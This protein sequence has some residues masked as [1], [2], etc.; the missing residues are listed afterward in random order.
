[1][2]G[3]LYVVGTPIGN[4]GDFSPRAAEVLGAVDFIAAE[5][6]RV[7]VK[8][9]NHFG[10]KKPL[11]S[12]YEHNKMDKGEQILNR[13]KN[14]ESCAVISDAG[15]PCISDPGEELV[16][17]AHKHG[18]K[19][20]V[21]PGPSAVISALAVSGMKS[22]RFTFEGFLSV[23]R[24]SRRAHLAE[25]QNEK[26]TMVFYEAPHKLLATLK[27][28]YETLGNREIT[29]ARELTKLHEEIKKTTLLDA[30]NY[31]SENAPKGEF[32]LLIEGK[33]EKEEN[34]SFADAVNFAKEWVEKGESA[35]NA[36]KR[37][38]ELTG[39]KKSEIYKELY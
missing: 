39:F 3:I 16:R 6:T 13:I 19:V 34:Y 31:Y 29:I 37:A 36:A 22:G 12:Y 10:I 2:A 14:G 26:R 20:E 38:A 28:F 32:V 33:P 8:L 7:S 23:N 1:M 30:F 25:I 15:M 21:V 5:D 35:S 27:D 9:L 11:I 4:L 18:V 24:P 17:E